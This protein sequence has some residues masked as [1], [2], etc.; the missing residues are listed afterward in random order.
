MLVGV[1]RP[2]SKTHF[3]FSKK[4]RDCMMEVGGLDFVVSLVI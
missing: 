3:A 2:L 1:D 4:G